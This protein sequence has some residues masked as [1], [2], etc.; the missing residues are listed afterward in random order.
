M[1]KCFKA[2]IIF[3]VIVFSSISL[4]NAQTMTEKQQQV[5]DKLLFELRCVTC[6]NQNLA[7]SQAPAALSMKYAVA[8]WVLEGKTEAQIRHALTARYGDYISY[9][10]PLKSSTYFLWWA[11]IFF[12]LFAVLAFYRIVRRKC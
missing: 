6:A 9:R 5:Y 3:F 12:S 7:E 10:P 8:Q 1:D 4:L 11:P 2:V